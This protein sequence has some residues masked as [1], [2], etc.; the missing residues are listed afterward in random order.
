MIHLN[1]NNKP[2]CGTRGRYFYIVD[3]LSKVT[4]G[5]CLG[6]RTYKIE[7]VALDG[8]YVGKIFTYS[9]GYDM[10]LNVFAKVIAQKGNVLIAQECLLDVSDD[11]GRG[12]GRAVAGGLKD[13]GDVY[14][15]SKKRKT[16]RYGVCEYW[17]GMGRYGCDLWDGKSK[18]H[19]TWD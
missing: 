12:N 7:G 4:C 3:D 10:T 5:K 14:K 19:N 8:D 2:K 1:K 15:I 13:G 18:Y 16:N 11:N 9:F 17:V 6:K